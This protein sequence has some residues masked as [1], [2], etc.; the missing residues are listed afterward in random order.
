MSLTCR[1]TNRLGWGF[2]AGTAL[3]TLAKETFG[4]NLE[5]TNFENSNSYLTMEGGGK[6]QLSNIGYL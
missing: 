3:K 6:Q 1:L 5:L 2:E 4:N